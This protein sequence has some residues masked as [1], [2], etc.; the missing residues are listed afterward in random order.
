[1]FV[2]T[3]GVVAIATEL[4]SEVTKLNCQLGMCGETRLLQIL[5][6]NKQRTKTDKD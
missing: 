3:L 1:M 2:W 4:A 5:Q 6:L